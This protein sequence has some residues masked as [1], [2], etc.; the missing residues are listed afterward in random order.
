MARSSTSMLRPGA[1]SSLNVRLPLAR[2]AS[3]AAD[4]ECFDAP[5]VVVPFAAADPT[6][7]R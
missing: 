5:F 1:T 6:M 3:M 4:D 7:V 2:S